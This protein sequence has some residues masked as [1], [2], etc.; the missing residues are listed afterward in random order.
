VVNTTYQLCRWA[1]VLYACDG[2]WWERY[3]PD[4][5]STFD[6]ELWTQD[7]GASEKY[8]LHRIDGNKADGLGRDKVHY[9]ANSGYQAINLAYLFGAKKMILLGFDM[10]RGEDKKS[11]WHGDHPGSLNTSMPIHTWIKNFRKLAEDLREE[12]VEVVNASRETALECFNKINLE[13]A[14]C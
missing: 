7:F 14:L 3:I 2:D 1:D 13:V 10:K 6:G 5:L 11:H 4:V 9:G 12:K 8:G